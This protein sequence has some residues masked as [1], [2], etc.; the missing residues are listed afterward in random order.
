MDEDTQVTR[1]ITKNNITWNKHDIFIEYIN[2][3]T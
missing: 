2:F 3:M 1:K